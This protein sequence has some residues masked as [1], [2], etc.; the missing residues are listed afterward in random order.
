MK[1][2]EAIQQ[3]S[4]ADDVE[5]TVVNLLY[6]GNWVHAVNA[7]VLKEH[8]LTTQQ[9]NVLRILKGRHP[10][11]SPVS[12]ISERMLDKMSNAS[13]LVEK[14]RQKGLVNRTISREDRRQVD[15]QLTSDGIEL[16]NRANQ[17]MQ[18]ALEV[19]RNLTPQE[20]KTLNQLLDKLRSSGAK[21]EKSE[22]K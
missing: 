22:I 20:S 1:I 7:S 6:T 5:K 8:G 3:K 14:L 18:I 19:F 2:E 4:F 10:E 13:R 17:S 11:P 9:Y 15:I 12:S 21:I 16:L